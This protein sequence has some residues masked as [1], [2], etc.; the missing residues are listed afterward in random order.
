[1]PAA[2]PAATV[3]ATPLPDGQ[4]MGASLRAWAEFCPAG[5]PG[6]TA[7]PADVVLNADVW[8]VLETVQRQ[9]NAEHPYRP[10]PLGR[11]S[12]RTLLPGEPGDCED[13]ALTK[14]ERLIRAGLPVGALR[15]ATCRLRG[16]PF[17][18]GDGHA[19]LTVET[20][21]GTYVL[22]VAGGAVPWHRSECDSWGYRWAGATWVSLGG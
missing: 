22:G 8:T 20:D 15:P 7:A 6:C 14:R 11:D 17:A 16:T 19:V 10:E 21:L 12:W 2:G 18:P 4:D 3:A 1:M 9:V 5:K 13:L